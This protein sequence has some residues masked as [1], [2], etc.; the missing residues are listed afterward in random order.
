QLAG[1]LRYKLSTFAQTTGVEIMI[2]I[3]PKV[4][5]PPRDVH[6]VS[7]V[8]DAAVVPADALDHPTR[9]AWESYCPAGVYGQTTHEGCGVMGLGNPVVAS[10][11]LWAAVGGITVAKRDG[12]AV[13]GDA[14]LAGPNSFA[15]YFVGDSNFVGNVLVYGGISVGHTISAH[16]KNAIV[17]FPD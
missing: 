9:E 14:T 6:G 3:P 4:P 12:T 1:M 11:N 2:D 8:T 7:G 16:T 5:F 10:G 17:P 15:G 13:Y